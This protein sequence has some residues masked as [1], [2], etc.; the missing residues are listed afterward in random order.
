[1]TVKV[2]SAVI[3][4]SFPLHAWIAKVD[5]NWVLHSEVNMRSHEI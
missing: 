4:T 2:I 3:L 1:M 5:D